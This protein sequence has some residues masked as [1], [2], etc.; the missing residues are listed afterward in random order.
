MAGVR[1]LE[2]DSLSNQ[3]ISSALEIGS[4][5]ADADRAVMVQAFVDA[6]A[7]N[8]DYVMYVTLQV[9]GSGSAYVILPKTTMAAA[10]GE[11]AIGGQSGWINVRNADVV[12]VYVD[13]LAGDTTT[14]DTIVRWFED[15]AIQ[16]TTAD[17]TLD[18]TA[19]GEAGIDW[20]NV[21]NPTTTVGLSGTTI[22]TATDVETDTADLQ[23]SLA[24]ATYGLSAIKVLVDDLESRLTAARAG[25]LDNLSAGAVALASGVVVASIANDAITAAAVKADAVTEIQSGLS[26]LTAAQVWQYVIETL[27]AEEIMIIALAA[28]AGKSDGGGTATVHFRDYGDAKNRITA[29]V[30]VDGNR[31][32]ITLDAT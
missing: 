20:G 13:G 17:R 32:A 23:S 30:D 14:P 6:V 5:T 15:A 9:G 22:K 2:T 28:L 11:T 7:G 4:Y 1:W 27:T 16:P 26:T 3:N 21:G 19:N 24:N 18:V 8:G 12:K 29:T 10:S 25:Y 31:T